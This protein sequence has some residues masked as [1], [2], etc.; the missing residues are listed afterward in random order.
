LPAIVARPLLTDDGTSSPIHGSEV[1]ETT[2]EER[3][4]HTSVWY[5]LALLELSGTDPLRERLREA[6]AV[7]MPS[8]EPEAA[9]PAGAQ[10]DA[11]EPSTAP[12]ERAAEQE[13]WTC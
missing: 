3:A 9:E 6:E 1:V 4:M 13:D 2:G 8:T 11:A 5:E 12:P 10:P 7:Q